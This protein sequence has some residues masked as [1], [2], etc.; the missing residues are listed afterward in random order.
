M[1]TVIEQTLARNNSTY[2]NV[3]SSSKY[4]GPLGAS[5]MVKTKKN[6]AQA[7]PNPADAFST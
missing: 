3:N 4:A 1:N 5:P 7:H 2:A 6:N